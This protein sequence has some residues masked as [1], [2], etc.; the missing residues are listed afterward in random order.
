MVPGLT[1]LLTE[2][3]TR[4]ISWGVKAAGALGWQPCHHQVPIVLKCWSL[5]LLQPSRPVQVFNGIALYTLKTYIKIGMIP[6]LGH[7]TNKIQSNDHANWQSSFKN[8]R[9]T[10]LIQVI[11]RT[12]SLQKATQQTDSSKSFI[13]PIHTNYY[14]IVKQFKSFKIITVAPTCFSLHKPSSGNSQSVLP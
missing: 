6:W 8:F 1:Q 11:A 10:S 5:K 7:N 2:M 4:N 3:S 14:K 12:L 13:C 9:F